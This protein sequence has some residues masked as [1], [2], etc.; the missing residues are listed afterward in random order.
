[1]GQIALSIF[2]YRRR[3]RHL[4]IEKSDFNFNFS[5]FL[6]VFCF[7]EVHSC[8]PLFGR[9]FAH[10]HSKFVAVRSNRKCKLYV[11]LRL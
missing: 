1:M 3:A 4:K 6:S 11:I 5:A 10:A 8:K 9:T 7:S 2:H